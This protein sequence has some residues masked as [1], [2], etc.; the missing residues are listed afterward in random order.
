[1]PKKPASPCV[2]ALR[3]KNPTYQIR[4]KTAE[5]DSQYRL[6]K[7]VIAAAK[8]HIPHGYRNQ[9]IPGW[10]HQCDELYERL[11][12]DHEKESAGR[13]FEEVKLTNKIEMRRHCRKNEL[14]ILQPQSLETTEEIR[15]QANNIDSRL[16]C[17]SKDKN[18]ARATKSS[19]RGL[20][21]TLTTEPALSA[22]F[23]VIMNQNLL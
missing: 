10:D 21:S 9:Y 17:V 7:T 13:L 11:N 18:H 19:I 1:V 5:S 20:K 23:N 6:A 3:P 8:R 14:H 22:N 16:L 12:S 4:S 15:H 2:T